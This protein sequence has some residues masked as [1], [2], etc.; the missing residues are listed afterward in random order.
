M[1]H[2]VPDSRLSPAS[3]KRPITSCA[4]CSWLYSIVCH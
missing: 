4:P 2:A 3:A 1:K